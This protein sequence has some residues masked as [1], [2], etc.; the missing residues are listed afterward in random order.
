M[1]E[2]RL[3][4][5]FFWFLHDGAG[6]LSPLCGFIDVFKN[7]VLVDSVDANDYPYIGMEGRIGVNAVSDPNVP[8]VWD[9]FGG[10]GM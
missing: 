3:R 6:G 9:D 10:G 7:E 8:D 5:L 4:A 2:G 1:A